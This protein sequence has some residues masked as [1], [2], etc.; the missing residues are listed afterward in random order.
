MGISVEQNYTLRIWVGTTKDKQS[1]TIGIKI[2]RKRL[3]KGSSF[4]IVRKSLLQQ[5]EQVCISSPYTYH[6]A[7]NQGGWLEDC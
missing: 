7:V 2:Y 1:D 4:E 3:P 5:I 6:I